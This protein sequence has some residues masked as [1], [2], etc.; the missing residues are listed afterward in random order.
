LQSLH[1]FGYAF[2]SCAFISL[3]ISLLIF[4]LMLFIFDCVYVNCF[5][6]IMDILWILICLFFYVPKRDKI[7][8]LWYMDIVYVIIYMH[9]CMHIYIHA[10]MYTYIGIFVWK[11]FLWCQI[12]FPQDI[13]IL[14]IILG[15]FKSILHPRSPYSFKLTCRDSYNIKI[16]DKHIKSTNFYYHWNK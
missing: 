5:L 15:I 10:C 1:A 13:I 14:T 11:S 12:K 6:A 2:V 3:W 7:V 8:M 9:A 16:F 4:E